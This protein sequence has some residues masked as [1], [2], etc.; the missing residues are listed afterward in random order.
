MFVCDVIWKFKP[1][2]QFQKTKVVGTDALIGLRGINGCP[3]GGKG[4]GKQQ[5]RKVSGK[6][7]NRV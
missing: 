7:V 6:M 3:H 4:D 1:S 2:I 5:T